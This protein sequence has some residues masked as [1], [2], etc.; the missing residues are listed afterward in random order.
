VLVHFQAHEQIVEC[1]VVVGDVPGFLTV[2]F[3]LELSIFFLLHNH[4]ELLLLHLVFEMTV[5]CKMAQFATC[6]A[7]F[8][9]LISHP[10]LIAFP[11]GLMLSQVEFHWCWSIWIVTSLSAV[12]LI[13]ILIKVA[14]PLS[15]LAWFS[16][17]MFLESL[18]IKLVIE[19]DSCLN[20]ILQV[21]DCLSIMHKFVLDIFL[22][23]SMEHCH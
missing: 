18:F 22:K 12:G 1:F 9:V 16:I 2:R 13:D 21:C 7:H 11:F 17:V 6:I 19:I 20:E 23:S 3:P 8:C 15:L 5:P 10:T 14:S 4:V